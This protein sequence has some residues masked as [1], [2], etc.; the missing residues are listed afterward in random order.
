MTK[1]SVSLKEEICQ[2]YLSGLCIKDIAAKVHINHDTI[3]KLLHSL[4]LVRPQGLIFSPEEED[5]IVNSYRAGISSI[6][7]AKQYH[8]HSS[9]IIKFLKTKGCPIRIAN[10]DKIKKFD[11]K[12]KE[13]IKKLWDDGLTR[14]QITQKIGMHS[15]TDK[16]VECLKLDWNISEHDIQNRNRKGI[17]SA[18]WK[19]GRRKHGEYI[20]IWLDESDPFYC[21]VNT[22]NAVLEHRYVMAKYLNRPLEKYEQVHHING[23]KSDNCIENLQLVVGNH[24]NGQV[25]RCIDCGSN[26]IEFVELKRT[27]HIPELPFVYSI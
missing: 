9:T 13:L 23:N 4:E 7:I 5:N 17:R 16:I 22:K 19:G 10:K 6:K 3:S 8:C 24:G 18:G 14:Y 12:T 26:N 1:I 27:P 20:M 25:C 21:M 11:Q 2:L 15:R